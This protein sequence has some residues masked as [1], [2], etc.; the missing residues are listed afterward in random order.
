MIDDIV[1]VFKNNN[2]KW[3]DY[4]Q[5]YN[6]LNE[7]GFKWGKNKNGSKGHKNMVSRELAS[8]H[9]DK[10]EIDEQLK[11]QKYRL[12]YYDDY[13]IEDEIS[14]DSDITYDTSD[15]A[16][17]EIPEFI[18]DT[19]KLFDNEVPKPSFVENKKIKSKVKGKLTKI[20]Y[21]KKNKINKKKG[22]AGE[23]AIFILEKRRLENLGRLDLSEQVEWVSQTKGNGLGYDI[24]SWDIKDGEVRKIYIE[25][26]TTE[27]GINKP[28]EISDTEVRISEELSE[29]YYIYRIFDMKKL[30]SKVNY[31]KVQGA[32]RENFE[33]R[34]TDYTAYI[35]GD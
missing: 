17:E 12:K 3:L 24:E 16:N 30:L 15:N 11:P 13:K 26:K 20:D 35:K 14:V 1:Q 7:E 8:R 10:F 31:Y 4:L 5:V 2:N 18:I 22:D 6:L 28:F 27:G 21:I 29:N 23:K 34:P 32:I 19:D 33:L 25:V 9:R